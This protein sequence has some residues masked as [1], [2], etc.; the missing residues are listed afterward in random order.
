MVLSKAIKAKLSS[1][2]SGVASLST[3]GLDLW[4]RKKT[5]ATVGLQSTT[6][7][8]DSSKRMQG[9]IGGPL[10]MCMRVVHVEE[11]WSTFGVIAGT[12][13]QI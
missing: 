1:I 8:G 10:S 11:G 9:P 2:P 7:R 3:L 4:Q 6:H 13:A 5:V 12:W